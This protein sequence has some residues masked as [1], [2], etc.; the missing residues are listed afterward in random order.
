MNLAHL[1]PIAVKVS[2]WLIVF[3][4][5]LHAS[6]QDVGYLLRRPGLLVRSLLAMNVVMPLVA[7]GWRSSTTKALTT[8]RSGA[9]PNNRS[10]RLA[11][12][13]SRKNCTV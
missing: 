4:V 2:M 10:H 3:S 7:A 6:L 8:N 11:H 5:A 12:G 1:I 9:S 13:T